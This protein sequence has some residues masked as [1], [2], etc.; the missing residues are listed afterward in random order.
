MASRV[1][2]SACS[3][4]RLLDEERGFLG[5][6]AGGQP[7]DDHVIDITLDAVAVLPV[8]VLGGQGMPVG[9]EEEAVVRALQANPVFQRAVVVAQVQ[10]AG[11]AHA[12]KHA[13]ARSG[14]G[15]FERGQGNS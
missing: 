4:M 15:R 11:R 5:V 1:K 14:S 6:D 3:G 2:S 8:L 9:N 10:S 13:R 7:V 12:R